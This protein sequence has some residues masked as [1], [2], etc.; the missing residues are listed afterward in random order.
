MKTED[1]GDGLTCQQSHSAFKIQNISHYHTLSGYC[2][3]K[4]LQLNNVF[5]STAVHLILNTILSPCIV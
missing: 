1:T 2:A 3:G 4:N 5:Y